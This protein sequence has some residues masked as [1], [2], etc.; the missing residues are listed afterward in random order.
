MSDLSSLI[1][2][3]KAA[4]PLDAMMRKL[5]FGDEFLKKSCLSPLRKEKNP[6]F[7]LFRH[8]NTGELKWKDFTTGKC[9]DQVDFL[10]ELRGRSKPEAIE[11]FLQ[12]AGVRGANGGGVNSNG[13]KRGWSAPACFNVPLPG[14]A[15]SK[16]ALP[17]MRQ[18]TRTE[19]EILATLR[20]LDIE[21]LRVAEGAG[22]LRFGSWRGSP[23]WFT[24]DDSRRNC[25]ARRLD[26]ALWPGIGCKVQTIPG[27]QA[28]WPLGAFGEYDTILLAEG[29]G[30]LLAAVHFIVAYERTAEVTASALL[31]ASHCRGNGCSRP[32]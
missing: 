22:L 19:L 3:A 4:L 11:E 17:E 27:S 10:M 25:Q 6:S 30:D 32:A 2:E 23:A 26:G 15:R 1:E 13:A 8:P 29:G 31:G 20:H 16:P 28:A 14:Q 7:G 12:M 18:G 5:R 24:L 21:A 9:G